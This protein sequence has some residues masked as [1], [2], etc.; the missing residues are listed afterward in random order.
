MQRS[1]IARIRTWFVL[2]RPPFHT[3]GILP[4]VLGTILAYKIN[5]VFSLEIFLLG[6]SGVILIMLSTYHS[7]EY[8]DYQGDVISSRLHENKFAGG[9][10]I[11]PNG[12]ISPLVPFRT[13]IITLILAGII[14][15]ILQ[16]VLKTGHYTLLLGCLGAFSGFFIP[17][18][19]LGLYKEASA[20]FSSAFAMDGCL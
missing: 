11:L 2:S 4:F 13:S 18:N 15:I 12:K 7:G 3:V 10:R 6:V 17:Q 5:S 20:R 16:F 8:F 9:T 19:P 1:N 14:G